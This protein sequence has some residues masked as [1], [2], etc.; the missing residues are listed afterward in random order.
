MYSVAVMPILVGSGIAHYTGHTLRWDILG[1]FLLSAVLILVWEN[2]CNDV[3]DAETGID[4]H[5]YHSLVQLTGNKSLVY[6]VA[7]G[8]L[9]L[10]LAGIGWICWQNHS[11]VV[12]GIILLACFLGYI[13]QA[14]PWRLGYQGLGEIL[15]FFSF[16]PLAV[17]AAYYSQTQSVEP[18]VWWVAVPVG[19]S[20]SLVLFCSHFHQVAD[21]LAAGKFSPV[22][23]LGTAVSAQL[24]PIICGLIYLSVMAG[25]ATQQLPPPTGLAVLSLPWAVALSQLLLKYHDRPELISHSKFIAIKF[26]FVLGLGLAV[27][28]WI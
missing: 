11:L 20:I 26:Q 9:A 12:A 2:L 5:K 7:N 18:V 13:Y 8:A 4:V 24:I 10:G 21:D 28:L 14:P 3:F 19:L 27:G 17:S 15:C 6:Q 22:V 23:R 1:V 16:G 25:I